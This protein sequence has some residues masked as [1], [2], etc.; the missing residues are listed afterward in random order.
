MRDYFEKT[1]RIGFSKWADDDY[2]LALQLWGE[3]EVTRYIS[4]NGKFTDEDIQK[5]L[6]LEISNQ[7]QFNVQYWPI[8]EIITGE[9][10]GC[11]GLRPFKPEEDIYEIGIH[12]RRRFWGQGLAFEAATAVLKYSFGTLKAEKK[13]AGHHPQNINSKKLLIRLGF[14]YIGDNFYEPTGLNHPSYELCNCQ[15]NRLSNIF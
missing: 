4:A 8:F 5:R 10:I 1:E 12:L 14:Q 6:S 9:L 11:C 15:L 7:R 13:F 3:G 2:P